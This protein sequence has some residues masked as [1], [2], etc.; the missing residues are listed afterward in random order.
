MSIEENKAIIR[1][2]FE[3]VW[4]NGNL[5]AADQFYAAGPYLEGLKQFAM[6]LYTAFPDWHATIE[7]LISEGDK[8]VV[9]WIGQGT[10]RAEW[11]G[12]QPTGKQVKIIGIDIERM[13]DGKIVEEHSN[14][15]M[16]GFLQQIGAIQIMGQDKTNES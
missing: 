11:D 15:D 2:L 1:H 13:V 6:A 5:A 7:D 9:Y 12:I 16:L 3:E 8:V 10:H 14:V 4:G